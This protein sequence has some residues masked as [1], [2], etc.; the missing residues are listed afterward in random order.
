MNKIEIAS[1]GISGAIILNI[2]YEFYHNR[3]FDTKAAVYIT[4]S[5]FL[6]GYMIGKK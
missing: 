5:S 6:A 3:K 1:L 2:G 4:V